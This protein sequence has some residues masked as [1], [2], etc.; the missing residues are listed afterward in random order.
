MNNDIDSKELQEM[1]A[2]LALLTQKL[3]QETIVSQ[4]QIRQSMKE[5]AN[6]LH[7]TLIRDCILCIIFIPVFI[8][9][10]PNISKISMLFCSICAI[11]LVL[12]LIHNCYM[13]YHFRPTTFMEGNLIEAR[14]YALNFKKQTR[15]YTYW[16]EVPILI[17][18]FILF[19]YE[20]CHF[21]EGVTLKIALISGLF[22][23]VVGAI[24]S[25]YELKKMLRTTNEI[26]SQ[27]EELEG[28]A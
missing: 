21:H 10:L 2:Q 20:K 5:K 4:R 1:K 26:L 8:G 25:Y 7:W 23:F 9:I 12:A 11:F 19:I 27:I 3:E 24:I 13:L 16:V 17:T 14:K 18:I 28:K 22:G 15:R 6:S